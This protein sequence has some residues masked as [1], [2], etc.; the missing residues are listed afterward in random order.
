[1]NK[2]SALPPVG[3][4][5]IVV[6]LALFALAV[7]VLFITY[8]RY[9]RLASLVGNLNRDNSFLRY[10]VNDFADAY[11]RHGKDI[12]SGFLFFRCGDNFLFD[13]RIVGVPDAALLQH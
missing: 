10:V 1:M 13:E 5:V 2:L 11:K 3:L 4:T 6:I 8:A 9:S 7:I 12:N